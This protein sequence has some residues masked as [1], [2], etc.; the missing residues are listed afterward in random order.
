MRTVT[1]KGII[2]G[3]GHEAKCTVSAKEVPNPAPLQPPAYTRYSVE[4]VEK[5]L[6]EGAYTISFNGQTL[7]IRYENGHWLATC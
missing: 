6:P 2:R 5:Q 7:A 4:H 1:F 3:N